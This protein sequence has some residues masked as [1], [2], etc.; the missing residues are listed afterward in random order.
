MQHRCK[1]HG[2]HTYPDGGRDA[3][4]PDVETLYDRI[5]RQLDT[6]VPFLALAGEEAF[7]PGPTPTLLLMRLELRRVA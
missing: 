3:T 6:L 7:E 4:R 5:M 2:V 1:L